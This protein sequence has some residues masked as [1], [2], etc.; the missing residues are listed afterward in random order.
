[1]D[2]VKIVDGRDVIEYPFLHARNK[3]DKCFLNILEQEAPWAA[4][5]GKTG[6]AWIDVADAVVKSKDEHGTPICVKV[7]PTTLQARFNSIMKL[8]DK[9]FHESKSK[10]TGADDDEVPCGDIYDRIMQIREM[11]KDH[12]DSLE[13]EKAVRAAK[14]KHDNNA[15]SK[16]RKAALGNL[17]R[18]GKGG[19]GS[20]TKAVD[21]SLTSSETGSDNDDSV[22][23]VLSPPLPAKKVRMEVASEGS[24]KGMKSMFDAATLLLK[25]KGAARK[26]KEERKLIEA[27]NKTMELEQRQAAAQNTMG[28]VTEN[29][30][31]E[32]VAKAVSTTISAI[33]PN[34]LKEAF[35]EFRRNN[36]GDKK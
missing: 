16:V 8:A 2:C 13:Q 35:A 15:G 30:L 25:E 21:T 20:T 7:A 31:D 6:Q 4:E 12:R 22:V 28:Y 29:D 24:S 3:K 26:S 14:A 32:K 5:H 1:M 36:N 18:R 10:K 17:K 23:E 34:L 11:V 19:K 33:V 9:W 27:R